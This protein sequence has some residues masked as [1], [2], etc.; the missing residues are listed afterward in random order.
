M[1]GNPYYCY[2]RLIIGFEHLIYDIHVGGSAGA[3]ANG[4]ER[5]SDAKSFPHKLFNF[6]KSLC[7]PLS[8]IW[9]AFHR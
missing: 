4:G 8:S 5:L 2:Y 7:V 9:G 6:V 3:G 1:K